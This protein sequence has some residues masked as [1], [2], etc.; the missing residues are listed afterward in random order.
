MEQEGYVGSNKVGR[1]ANTTKKVV[2]YRCI[3]TLDSV[4]GIGEVETSPGL[5]SVRAR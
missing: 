2:E 1:V 3:N 5:G 4:G